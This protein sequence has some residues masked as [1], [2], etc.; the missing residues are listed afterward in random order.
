MTEYSEDPDLAGSRG[1][2]SLREGF[3][4]AVFFTF[5]AATVL[6][7]IAI[8]LTLLIDAVGFFAEYSVIAFLTGMDWSPSLRPVSFGVLP[9]VF[10]TLVVTAIAALIAIPVG[11]LTAVYLSEYAPSRTRA[12]L[13][14]LLEILA[15]VPTVIYGFFALVYVTPVIE[16]VFPGVSTF[17][18]LSASL[19][20]GIMTIPMVSSISEDAMS[21]VPDSLRRAGYGMGATKYEVTTDIIVPAATSG[22]VSSYILAISRAIGETM[23]VTVAMGMQPALPTVRYADVLGLGIPFVHPGEVFLSSGQTM[24]AAMVQIANSDLA[25]GTLAYNSLFAIG[26]TLFVITLLMNVVSNIISERYREEY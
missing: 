20:V 21:A 6:T 12:I 5:A 23:I 26:L 11:T 3:Y 2:Q 16:F 17:N 24:T 4:K 13:K 14:P 8:I 18:V 1:F 10:G 15:G 19:L 25:G 7:T 22:I 9:L